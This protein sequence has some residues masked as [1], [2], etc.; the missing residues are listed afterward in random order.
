MSRLEWT[1]SI[2]LLFTDGD[3]SAY[4]SLGALVEALHRSSERERALRTDI[5]A[6]LSQLADSNGGQ[7]LSVAT[8]IG[9]IR[10]L[11]KGV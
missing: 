6:I 8:C 2:G 1:K 10:A 4:V 5:E 7:D 11:L 3:R 9:R